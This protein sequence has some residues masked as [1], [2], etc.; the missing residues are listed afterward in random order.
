MDFQTLLNSNIGDFTVGGIASAAINAI[1][2]IFIIKLITKTVNKLLDKV[3]ID[4]KIRKLINISL[5]TVLYILASLIVID[6]LGVPITSLVALLSVCSI[7]LTLAAEDILGNV[8]G[9]IVIMSTRPFALGDYIEVDGKSGTVDDITIN[10]TKIVSSDGFV[11][12]LPNKSLAADKITNY[13]HLGR[14][15]IALKLSVSYD[16]DS[17]IV[18]SACYEALAMTD[19]IL[20]EPKTNVALTGFKDSYIEYTIFCWAK[21]SDYWAVSF[22]LNENV[23]TCFDKHNVHMTYNHLNV[24]ILD[25]ENK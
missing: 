18:K 10:Y 11:I 22:A 21:T 7:A 13:T 19:N 6:A 2:C 16:D 3:N 9:G 12:T 25:G 1:I 20:D 5:R 24:H 23:R 8:A 15:R 4:T 14:R 17:A